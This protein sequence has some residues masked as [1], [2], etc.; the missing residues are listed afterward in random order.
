LHDVNSTGYPA[1]GLEEP[2]T[3]LP[4]SRPG[5]WDD[6]AAPAL[7]APLRLHRATVGPQWVDYNGHMSEWCYLLVMGDSS[8]AFF[9][10]VGIDDAY[11]ASGRSLYTVETHLRN[12]AEA[13]L[14]DTLELTL[15]VLAVDDKRVHLAHELV[16]LDT[17]P[18]TGT[19]DGS[20]HGPARDGLATTL[21]GTGEQLL[22]HVDAAAAR[23]TPIPAVLGERLG[24]LAQAHAALPVLPWVGRAIGAGRR[25][26]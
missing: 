17:A 6:P 22:V 3:K 13:A 24:R 21:V 10:F 18:G 7:P 25:E 23:A 19:Q 1:A 2:V 8:D 4:S 14:G 20:G 16:R 26:G 11:R 9:R 5:G 15:R 12:L